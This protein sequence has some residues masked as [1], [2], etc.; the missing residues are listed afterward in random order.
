MISL[1]IV[2]DNAFDDA[3]IIAIPDEIFSHMEE[4]GK[5]FLKWVMTAEDSDYWMIV[6]G[7]KCVIAETDG[8][9]K[10]LNT[11]YCKGADKAYL[12]AKN[13]NYDSTLKTIEF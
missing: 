10:W 9:I 3:D 4:I 6:D 2:F 13:T 8:F 11:T 12:V 1:N 5:E 7:R